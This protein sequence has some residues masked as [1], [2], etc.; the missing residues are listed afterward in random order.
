MAS[1]IQRITGRHIFVLGITLAVAVLAQAQPQR[2]R[3]SIEDRVKILKDSLKLTDDQCTKITKIFEDQR[4]EMAT[5]MNEN[6]DNPDAMKTVRQEIMKKTDD[7]IKSILTEDQVAK[8][9]EMLKTRR[10]RMGRRTRESGK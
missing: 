3:I 10:E 1:Y 6:K 2:Q 7:Q 4:E 8:Y 9:D 5:A